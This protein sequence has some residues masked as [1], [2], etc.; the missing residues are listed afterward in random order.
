MAKNNEKAGFWKHARLFLEK[1]VEDNMCL[2]L[3]DLPAPPHPPAFADESFLWCLWAQ[4]ANRRQCWLTAA[5]PAPTDWEGNSGMGNI[6]KAGHHAV[7]HSD[8]L[9]VLHGK[10]EMITGQNSPLTSQ[11]GQKDSP[12]QLIWAP[13][14]NG[15]AGVKNTW[16]RWRA[17]GS[18][19]TVTH[20]HLS[21]VSATFR[22][23]ETPPVHPPRLQVSIHMQLHA[24]ER[25]SSFLH[26]FMPDNTYGTH[27]PS[28]RDVKEKRT[29][30]K[31]Y[32]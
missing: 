4:T 13:H 29:K 28:W 32:G 30:A 27:Q 5:L 6:N 3:E 25:S 20:L 17:P 24:A 31:L 19:L 12:S 2:F 1:D 9:H 14:A 16:W 22:C 18:K 15:K 10:N 11:P 21:L 26:L 7:S 8:L 23:V